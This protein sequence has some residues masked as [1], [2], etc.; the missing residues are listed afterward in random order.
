MKN[1][2]PDCFHVETNLWNYGVKN[3]I[4]HI[5]MMMLYV[6]DHIITFLKT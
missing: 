6:C 5:N 4:K 2:A 1:S 3:E